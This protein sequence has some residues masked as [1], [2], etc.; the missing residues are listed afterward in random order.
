MML[1]SFFVACLILGI[2]A[3]TVLPS[4]S[5]GG[6]AENRLEPTAPALV[7]TITA[8]R[9]TFASIR[10]AAVTVTVENR[11][12]APAE[13][14]LFVANSSI[15]FLEVLD[16]GERMLTGPP[17]TPPHDLLIVSLAPGEQRQFNLSL[18]MFGRELPPGTYVVR[19][20]GP[21]TSNE[22]EFTIAP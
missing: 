6:E 3:C 19:T 2:A 4:P 15:L 12:Y 13:L 8:E 22:L 20:R 11:S 9:T 17:P 14:S 7:A 21:E 18:N 1:Y 10:D 16:D 5:H